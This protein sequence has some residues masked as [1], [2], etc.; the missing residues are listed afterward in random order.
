MPGDSKSGG[1]HQGIDKPASSTKN[2][3]SRL[4]KESEMVTISSDEDE[5]AELPPPESSIEASNTTNVKLVYD[6]EYRA[7]ENEK[8]AQR[9]K[10]PKRL[11]QTSLKGYM[12]AVDSG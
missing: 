2:N 11:V 4:A 5:N 9:E 1:D 3:E 12:K 7:P 6:V 10:G 8:R